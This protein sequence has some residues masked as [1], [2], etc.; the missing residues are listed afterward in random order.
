M[1]REAKHN[2]ALTI[3]FFCKKYSAIWVEVDAENAHRLE[4]ALIGRRIDGDWPGDSDDE[5]EMQD[6]AV[7]SSDSNLTFRFSLEVCT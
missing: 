6:A 5:E 7:A 4:W 3:D 2:L 1:L